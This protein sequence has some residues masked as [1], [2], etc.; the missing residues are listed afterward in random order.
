M[1]DD[2]YYVKPAGA[3][4]RTGA[5][6]VVARSDPLTGNVLVALIRPPHSGAYVLPKGG[7]DAGETLRQAAEREIREEA[8]FTRVR[9]L[10]EL[11]VA[12][13]LNGRRTTW[14]ATHYFLFLTDQLEATPTENVDWEVAWFPP[15]ALPEMRWR[16]QR[17]LIEDNR[18]RI[19]DLVRSAGGA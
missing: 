5:G 9:C 7:V 6:G 10:A 14:Q 16:E 2:S 4:T 13:R 1:N 19:R 11:G 3:R 15:D 12:Q 18:Q 8:G 17:A